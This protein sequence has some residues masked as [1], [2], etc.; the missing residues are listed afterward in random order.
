[1]TNKLKTRKTFYTTFELKEYIGLEQEM[2]LKISAG[3]D[4]SG[5][6]RN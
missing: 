1:M 4:E 3:D 2:R 5:I 6:R